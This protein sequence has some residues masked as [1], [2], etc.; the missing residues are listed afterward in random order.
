[1]RIRQCHK[2]GAVF[3]NF[4]SD[5]FDLVSLDLVIS[6]HIVCCGNLKGEKEAIFLL[7]MGPISMN[8]N[9]V[10]HQLGSIRRPGSLPGSL[11]IHLGRQYGPA[12]TIPAEKEG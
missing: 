2:N 6:A 5:A 1:M 9:C 4:Q 12:N 3:V 7:K 11:H 8:G 10:F